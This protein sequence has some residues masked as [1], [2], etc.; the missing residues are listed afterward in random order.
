MNTTA[1]IGTMP[2]LSRVMTPDMMVSGL[3]C[4]R[5]LTVM[6]GSRLAGM[7][8]IIAAINSAQVR[9]I[10][11]GRRPCTMAPQRVQVSGAPSAS[12]LFIS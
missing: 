10:L 6:I 8:R 4:P 9:T 3:P 2:C 11:F 7:Y 5:V 1:A 12:C